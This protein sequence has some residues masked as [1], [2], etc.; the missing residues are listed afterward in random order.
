[1]ACRFFEDAV[2]KTKERKIA[3]ELGY[4][5]FGQD[6]TSP[7]TSYIQWYQLVPPKVHLCT[8]LSAIHI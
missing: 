3:V 1:M 2:T 5:D 6:D 7:I 8:L 4:N